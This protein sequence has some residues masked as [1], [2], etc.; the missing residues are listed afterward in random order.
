MAR[1]QHTSPANDI[2][3][4]YADPDGKWRWQ[5]LTVNQVLILECQIGH[6]DYGEC[7]ADAQKNGYVLQAVP[8]TPAHLRTTVPAL[9]WHER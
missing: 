6:T 2:W 4:F 9:R 7:V 3:R 8:E 1:F 5:Y